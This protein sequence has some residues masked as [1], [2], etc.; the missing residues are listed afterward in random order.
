MQISRFPRVRLTHAPTPLEPLPNL[1]RHLGG[2]NLF[3][4][5][6]DCTGL[7]TGGNKTRKLEFLIG[8]ALSRGATHIITQGATQ[9]NH[10]RQTGAAAAKLGLRCTALLEER[11]NNG[12]PE[13]YTSG[14]VLLNRLFGCRLETRPAGTDMDQE[15]ADLGELLRSQGETPYLIPGGGSNAIGALG[16]VVCAQEILSQAN[17]L[18]LHIDSVVHATGSTGTQ[19]GLVAGF[20]GLNSGIRVLGISVRAPREEQ[21][22]NVY[23]LARQTWSHLGIKGELSRA[24]VE[25]DSD[26]VGAGYGQPTAG[27]IEAVTLAAQQEGV[28]LDPVYTGKGLAGLIG[29]IRA[30]RFRKDENIIFVHTGGTAGLFGYIQ[31]FSAE[32]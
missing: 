24:A 31:V 7:A 3:I 22:E 25:A 8:D 4:K 15:L 23:R 9:S 28:L 18:G 6:D 32:H 30:G 16:Y 27:M 13:Y 14:N 26:Y 5:R 20:E 2:P 12:S 17:D 21:E 29:L 1:S 10:V 19:A 11:V